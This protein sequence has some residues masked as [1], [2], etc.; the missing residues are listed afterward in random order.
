MVVAKLA[1]AAIPE[2]M[3]SLM[4]SGASVGSFVASSVLK[5]GS[6]WAIVNATG[7][8]DAKKLDQAQFVAS[9]RV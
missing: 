6:A 2:M 4:A 1:P 5:D 3:A 8:C 7:Q 9:L